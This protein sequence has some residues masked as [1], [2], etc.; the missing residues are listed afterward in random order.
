MSF[1]LNASIPALEEEC[2]GH[3]IRPT[4]GVNRNQHPKPTT[5][6]ASFASFIS[7]IMAEP[8]CISAVK[9]FPAWTA[10]RS[11]ER[12]PLPHPSTRPYPLWM[13]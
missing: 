1:K 6:P 12:C 5:I 11:T 2:K 8:G 13:W 3:S 10:A 9:G 4:V 7:S